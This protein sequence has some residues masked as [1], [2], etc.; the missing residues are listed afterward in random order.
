MLRVFFGLMIV[1]MLIWFFLR[2]PPVDLA[3]DLFLE[4]QIGTDSAA[5]DA[6]RDH[7]KDLLAHDA[8]LAADLI[9]PEEAFLQKALDGA[10]ADLQQLL[11]LGGRIDFVRVDLLVHV[12]KSTSFSRSVK[13]CQEAHCHFSFI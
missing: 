7:V 11:G 9:G 10:V 5:L 3:D 12:I 1:V 8:I 4:M 13:R 2:S 6:G